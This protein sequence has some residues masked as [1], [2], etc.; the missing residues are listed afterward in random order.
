LINLE[1][2]VA[3]DMVDCISYRNKFERLHHHNG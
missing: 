3:S 1:N 2:E